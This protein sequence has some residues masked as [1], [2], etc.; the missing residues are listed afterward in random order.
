M[1]DTT[2]LI[3]D[4]D[5]SIRALLTQTLQ[6]ENYAT[7]QA[8]NGREALDFLEDGTFSPDL[9]LL[10]LVMP[11]MTGYDVLQYLR[12]QGPQPLP[13]LI[14]SGLQP[15]SAILGA[16]NAEL[17]DFVAKPFELEE[18]L[19]R[20]QAL[21]QRA[22]RPEAV[23]AS[24]MR[25]YALGSLRI[26]RDDALVFDESWRNKPAKAIFKRL[27]SNPGQRYAKDM[28]AD[29]L[30]PET[31]PDTAI[32]RLR[33]AIHELR[34]ML[35]GA[36]KQAGSPQ[37]IGQQEGAY[38][39]DPSL[40]SWSDVEAFEEYAQQG[41]SLAIAGR[42]DEALKAFQKAEALYQ[43]DYLRDDP[44][45][46]WTI[47]IRER[48]RETRLSVLIQAAQLH[49]E[50]GDFG[51]AAA[52]CRRILRCDPWREEV[53]RRMMEYLAAAGRSHE[54][55]RAFEECRRVLQAEMDTS[56]SH[57]TIQVRDRIARE[58]NTWQAV[59]EG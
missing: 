27:F 47:P 29:E 3:V 46:A 36:R 13:V 23:P 44:Y 42:S 53:Y 14:M 38:F 12:K 40:G 19:I 52:L 51:E 37:Y 16:L 50:R 21:L 39:F 10:D 32:N 4:D 1:H 6:E 11:E 34:K 18:M 25:T 24:C 57:Q 43:G 48:L 8:A 58:L 35:R 15:D 7:V 17:R 31:E 2:I 26:Y 20:I 33:V 41:R 59:G 49:A 56:P 30:W 9:M 22:P 55:L 45:A 28:L 54:A 5:A